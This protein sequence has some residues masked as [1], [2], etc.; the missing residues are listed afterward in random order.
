MNH[1]EAKQRPP[2]QE[3]SLPYLVAEVVKMLRHLPCPKDL[4]VM[5]EEAASPQ[6]TLYLPD[7]R[8]AA[9]GPKEVLTSRCKRSM[10]GCR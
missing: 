5:V 8:C 1:G 4:S 3:T 10:F 9:A 2:R 7:F 6:D